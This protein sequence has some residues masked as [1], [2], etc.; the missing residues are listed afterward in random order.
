MRISE[1]EVKLLMRAVIIVSLL[2]VFL[3]LCGSS[4]AKTDNAVGISASVSGMKPAVIQKVWDNQAIINVGDF[5]QGGSPGDPLLP[6][7]SMTLLVPPNADLEKLSAG[8]ASESWEELP[9]EYEI[10]PVK[11]AAASN[12]KGTVISWGNK[13][14]SLIVDGKDTSIY[15]SDAYFPSAPLQ[16]VSVGKFRQFK[17]VELRVWLA[18]YNPVQKKVRCLKTHRLHLQFKNWR[19]VVQS[20]LIR[21]FCRSYQKQKNSKL[22]CGRISLTRRI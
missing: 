19:L 16:I 6:Y 7:K 20:G 12:D 2:A 4:Q 18:A 22:N 15:G 13:D 5:P 14:K 17:L 8:L 9:G 11:P 1:W 3:V 10:A 21:L